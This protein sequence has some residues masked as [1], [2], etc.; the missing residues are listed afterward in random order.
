MS[1]VKGYFRYC[2][3]CAKPLRWIREHRED[4]SLQHCGTCGF[5][6]YNNPITATEAYIVRNGK[7]LMVRRGQPPKKGFLDVPGGFMDGFESPRTGIIREIKEEIGCVFSPRGLL[8]A[9]N[10]HY[11]W[12]GKDYA[13]VVL[14]YF[15]TIKGTPASNYEIAEVE[16]VPLNKIPSRLA[17]AHMHDSIRDLKRSLRDK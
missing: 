1:N 17:F 2:P 9:Y 4:R 12:K 6:F 10:D 13:V 15:G 7:L 5:T 16:W 3:R 11:P 8:G 14:S